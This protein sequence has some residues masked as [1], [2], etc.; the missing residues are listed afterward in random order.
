MRC[1]NILRVYMLVMEKKPWTFALPFNWRPRWRWK[2]AQIVIQYSFQCYVWI[3]F[4]HFSIWVR[5]KSNLAHPSNQPVSSRFDSRVR[6]WS[7]W[8]R[9]Y[10]RLLCFNNIS[11]KSH[12]SPSNAI[13]ADPIY[14]Y[15]KRPNRCMPYKIDSVPVTLDRRGGRKWV[16]SRKRKRENR[17][18]R[19]SE[20]FYFVCT[21]RASSEQKF[22]WMMWDIGK[23]AQKPILIKY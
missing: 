11:R 4:I 16:K 21:M 19:K 2:K 23:N 1:Q 10:E 14:S 15:H 6:V 18:N 22:E 3:I 5:L 8:L 12:H 7:A 20:T 17:R 9:A 13:Y